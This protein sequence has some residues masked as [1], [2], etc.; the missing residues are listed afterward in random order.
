MLREGSWVDGGEPDTRLVD[1]VQLGDEVLEVD[2]VIRVVVE[3]ELLEVPARAVPLAPATFG[4]LFW[5]ALT[6]AIPRQGSPSANAG[7]RPSVG[8]CASPWPRCLPSP[9]AS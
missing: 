9:P 7:A 6:T 5:V 4:L 2:V 1:A 3:D 8:R